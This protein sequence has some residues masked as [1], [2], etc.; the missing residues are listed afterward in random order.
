MNVL[1]LIVR[2]RNQIMKI[3]EPYG[4]I[5]LKLYGSVLIRKEKPE[6]DID[7]L[8]VF[9]LPFD[10]EA[11]FKLEEG[12]E[13]Y[14]GRRVSIV[15]SRNIPEAFHPSIDTDPVDI[16][17]LSSEKTYTITPKTSKLY[18]TMLDKMFRESMFIKLE[19]PECAEGYQESGLCLLAERLSWWFSRLL[20]VEDN[21]LK[22]Y[23]GFNYIEVLYLCD[24]LSSITQWD[25]TEK[26]MYHFKGLLKPIREYV[27]AR[28][29]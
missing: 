10:W 18:S 17:E 26:D 3:V 6:S 25:Y 21:D 29:R 20:R 4:V 22:K 8:A 14:F 1:D 13:Q 23:S 27:Q 5:Q 12:L 2:D 11:K 16:M 24:K 15:D 19:S 7:F 9:D 28:V